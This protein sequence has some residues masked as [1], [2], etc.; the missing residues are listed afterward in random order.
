M[1]RR[2]TVAK[3][4]ADRI[5]ADITRG[6][7][8]PGDWLPT[9]DELREK[10]GAVEDGAGKAS[11][12]A[13]IGA[14]RILA[15][16]GHIE[17]HKNKGATVTAHRVPITPTPTDQTNGSGPWRGFL[18]AAHRAGREP[19]TT[20]LSVDEVEAPAEVADRMG[21]PVGTT[22]LRRVRLQGTVEEGRQIPGLLSTA[23][24]RAG[25]VERVPDLRQPP[26]VFVPIRDLLAR[27][28]LEL[29]YEETATTRLADSGERETLKLSDVTSDVTCVFDVWRVCTDQSDQVVDVTR[30]VVNPAFA[31]L[32]YRYS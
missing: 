2:P 3:D 5:V 4:I 19:Y 17:I 10:H 15:K 14:L 1:G 8:A 7:Y 20:A 30:M 13:V 27:S 31:Q 18:A 23:W 22:V 24:F 9:Q 16:D 25:V 11:R 28:G 12:A 6:H 21:V 29:R 26:G 32:R